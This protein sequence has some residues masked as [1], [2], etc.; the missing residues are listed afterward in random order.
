[1]TVIWGYYPGGMPMPNPNNLNIDGHRYGYQG[2]EQD[3]EISGTGNSYTSYFRQLDTRILRWWGIDPKT[4]SMPW[5]SPY[6]S[7]DGNPV[8]Y[9][10]IFGDDVEISYEEKG[11]NKTLNYE[12]GQEYAGDNDFLKTTIKTLNQIGE[13]ENGNKVLSEL[14]ESDNVFSVLNEEGGAGRTSLSFSKRGEGGG[15]IKAGALMGL[16]E[17]GRV[18]KLGHE[19]FHGFQSENG[20]DPFTI[21]SEVGASLFGSSLTGF[22]AGFSGQDPSATKRYQQAFNNLLYSPDEF[23]IKQFQQAVYN[24]KLGSGKNIPTEKYPQ[25]P[26]N[27]FDVVNLQ[28]PQISNF[29]PLLKD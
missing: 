25:G 27:Q 17:L 21:D 18:E 24:F 15:T 22:N 20:Q 14:V 3:N 12:I 26:Y 4:S 2:S 11:E 16:G 28:N 6:N 7:M 8:L 9:N 19:L 13:N 23:D 10:D 1:M 29:F 5:Q